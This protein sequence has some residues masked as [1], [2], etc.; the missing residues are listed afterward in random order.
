MNNFKG[1]FQNDLSSQSSYS[2]QNQRGV[3]TQFNKHQVS[4][5]TRAMMVTGFGFLATFLIGIL[6][7]YLI[8]YS[9]KIGSITNINVL[10]SITAVGLII[11]FGLSIIWSFRV[12]KASTGFATTTI[13]VYCIANGVGFGSLFYLVEYWEIMMVFGVLGLIFLFTFGISKI[14]SSK[15]VLSLMKIA[16]VATI[17]YLVFVLIV[18]LLSGFGL[19]SFFSF[20]YS[21]LIIIAVSG[22]LSIFYLVY[23]LW[24]IQNLDKFYLDNELTKKLS[25]FMGFQILMNLINLLW[26]F[27]RVFLLSR[28]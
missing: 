10:F 9:I 27:L 5:L 23:E 15:V 22:L 12:Y 25:I 8:D 21:Y 18:G 28:K 1:V 24:I 3:K 4:S 14:I 19:L 2:Y 20:G 26:V 13:I 11:S 6:I 16:F 7:E 17:V